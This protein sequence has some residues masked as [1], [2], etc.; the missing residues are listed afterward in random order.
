MASKELCDILYDFDIDESIPIVFENY[1]G[2]NQNESE[3]ILIPDDIISA[4]LDIIDFD[5][6]IM[7]NTPPPVVVEE[8]NTPESV[9]SPET[10]S[11]ESQPSPQN[12][13]PKNH[14]SEDQSDNPSNIDTQN[15]NANNKSYDYSVLQS[16]FQC[17]H[18][19]TTDTMGTFH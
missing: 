10:I 14:S 6:I 9:T 4:D 5:S 19:S 7:E 12:P 16:S 3:E 11:P 13:S 15:T 1:I 2:E 18:Y 8:E 17:Y